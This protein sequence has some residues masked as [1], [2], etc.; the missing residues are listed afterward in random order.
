MAFFCLAQRPEGVPIRIL[1]QNPAAYA[2]SVFGIP[3]AVFFK[4]IG[5][6]RHEILSQASN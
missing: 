5:A 2:R 1:A 6:T 4:V 3:V